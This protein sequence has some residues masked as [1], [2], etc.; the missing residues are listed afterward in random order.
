[1]GNIVTGD[2]QQTQTIIQVGALPSL[3]SLLHSPKKG[4][5]KEACWTL[6]NITAGTKLQIQAAIDAGLIPPL[7]RH[8]AEA[9][10]EIKKEAAWAI[11]NATS[12]G[13]PEQI[14]YLVEAGCIKPLCELLGCGDAKTI[15]VALE[16]IENILKV[17]P[18]DSEDY[19]QQIEEADGVVKLETLQNH[20]NN[21]IYSKVF[22]ILEK[23]FNAEEEGPA[24][25]QPE[26]KFNFGTP[27]PQVFN[28]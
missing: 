26:L 20:L 15:L 16:G 12:G 14:R 7:I 27:A 3:L 10:F 8:L 13:T 1:V 4:I 6:S 18:P 25:P 11:S 2:D 21:D 23:H 24:P 28:F 5:K 17:G 9:E 19:V 22:S